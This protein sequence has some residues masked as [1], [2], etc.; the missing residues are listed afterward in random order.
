MEPRENLVYGATPF[1]RCLQR[2][3]VY[4][5]LVGSPGYLFP[6]RQDEYPGQ[7]VTHLTYAR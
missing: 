5:S 1:V 4:D 2:K 7:V 6:Y 3:G